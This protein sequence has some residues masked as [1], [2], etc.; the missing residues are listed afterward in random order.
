[1]Y[2]LNHI[3]YT[4]YLFLKNLEHNKIQDILILHYMNVA[5]YKFF[6]HRQNLL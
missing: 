5:G 3:L 2:I 1:M 4:V 6:A